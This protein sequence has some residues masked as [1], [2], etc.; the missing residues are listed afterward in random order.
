MAISGSYVIRETANNLKRN[1]VMTIGAMLT[2]AVSLAL[3]GGVL[4]SRQAVNKQTAQWK[5]GVELSIFMQPDAAQSQ[6]DAIQSQL[7][8]LRGV[9]RMKFVDHQAAFDEMK[10]I[11]QG[12]PN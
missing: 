12:E 3:M 9:K 7:D 2:G 10:K 4:L 8:G 5:G 6:I 11:F 1:L